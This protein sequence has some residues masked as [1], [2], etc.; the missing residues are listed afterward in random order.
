MKKKK[1][2][3]VTL[4]ILGLYGC[5]RQRPTVIERPVFDVWSS[6]ILEIDKI[7]MSDS[8]TV[9]HIDAY[10][11]PN[12]SIKIDNETY[13]QKSGSNEKILVIRA[14]GINLDEDT[15]MPE[16]G[17][18][19]F[20]LFFPPLKKGITKIDFIE[21][22]YKI[23]GIRLLPNAKIKF[24]PIPKDV[25]TTSDDP[26]PT[27]EYNTQPAQISGQ[28][29]GYVNGM[30]INSVTIIALNHIYLKR[31]EIT[32][33]I[34]EDGSFSGGVSLGLAGIYKSSEGLLFLTPGKETKIYVD[35]K[36]RSR[37]Q[38]RYRTDKEP[39]DS[40]Y[41]YVSG[42][43]TS[44]ELD[45]INKVGGSISGVPDLANSFQE[46]YQEIANM[47][48]EE[49]KQYILGFMNKRLDEIRQKGYSANMQMMMENAIKIQVYIIMM[50]YQGLIYNAY[51]YTNNITTLEERD[52]VTFRAEIPGAEYYSVMKEELNND[53]ISYLPNFG[54]LAVLLSDNDYVRFFCIPDGR[55]EPTKERLAYFNEKFVSVMGTDKSILLAVIQ[56]QF[57]GIQLANLKYFTETEKQEIRD[58]FRDRPVYAETLI[59]ESDR[60]EAIIT[61]TKENN[62]SMKNEPP[63]VPQEQML[64]AILAKY[65]GKVVVMD[66]WGTWCPPCMSAMRTIQPLKDEMKGKDVVFLYIADEI[67]PLDAWEQTYPAISGEHYRVKQAQMN[68][69]G[70]NTYPSYMVYDRQG[71]ELAKYTGFPG[72][73]VMKRTIEKGL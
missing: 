36:K 68:Y 4:C 46:L 64:D 26:L 3:L 66:I 7:E 5:N 43:F 21:S 35:L 60:I 34:A 1:L 59:A 47:T 17:M 29:L 14:E 15:N 28:M 65:N 40:I 51:V 31:S 44:A 73:D 19:S 39:D 32:I 53:S 55:D 9:F 57:Y 30:D 12:R 8:A 24:D 58:I 72:I 20:K 69:W 13:I 22:D 6:T 11:Q 62:E 49:F 33:P 37:F 70:I 25:A 27:P 16:S 63:D 2:L 56:S 50:Q 61:A 54:V 48:P 67:S 71:K 10:Y 38:S 42:N 52:K 41:T 18:L 45:D 23:W